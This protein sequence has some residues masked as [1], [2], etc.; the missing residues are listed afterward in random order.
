MAEEKSIWQKVKGFV[1]DI[2]YV[3]DE[4]EE[5]EAPVKQEQAV[6]QPVEQPVREE[7]KE[8]IAQ[9]EVIPQPVEK[10]KPAET[11]AS[12]N[13]DNK[14]ITIDRK[15]A[16]EPA[17]EEKKPEMNKVVSTFRRVEII[18]PV[19]PSNKFNN[20]V[21]FDTKPV[22]EEKS[23]Y[24][25]IVNIINTMGPQV[26]EI[27]NDDIDSNVAAL[28]IDDFTGYK[29]A[30]ASEE[31]VREPVEEKETE[32]AAEPVLQPV[33]EPVREEAVSQMQASEPDNKQSAY[34]RDFSDVF[35]TSSQDVIVEKKEEEKKEPANVGFN[36]PD[37]LAEQ[38]EKKDIPDTGKYENLSLFDFL[39][40]DK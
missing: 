27:R 28:S 21:H 16:S 8:E 33:V 38:Q 5:A 39:Q 15:T 13:R 40:E 1:H 10:P 18:S 36:I 14:F 32:K 3:S 6:I 22:K 34:I 4:E 9:P 11:V 31:P 29:P 24:K 7:V 19:G 26:D 2:I 37:Y 30:H 20:N 12:I 25:P 23:E 17:G 35:H